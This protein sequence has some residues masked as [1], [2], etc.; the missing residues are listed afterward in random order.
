M[1]LNKMCKDCPIMG[2]DC[3]GTTCQDWTG[4]I[5]KWKALKDAEERKDGKKC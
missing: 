2:K 1:E 3:N 4:C 5:F